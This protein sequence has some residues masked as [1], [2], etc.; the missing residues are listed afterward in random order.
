MSYDDLCGRTMC[1]IQVT[2]LQSLCILYFSY[3]TPLFG[4]RAASKASVKGDAIGKKTKTVDDAKLAEAPQPASQRY[5]LALRSLRRFAAQRK[6]GE[7][8]GDDFCDEFPFIPETFLGYLLSVY[9]IEVLRGASQRE[10]VRSSEIW[11]EFVQDY[12]VI[13]TAEAEQEL[14]DVYGRRFSRLLLSLE[15]CQLHSDQERLAALRREKKTF[16]FKRSLLRLRL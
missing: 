13:L 6:E 10:H 1:S 7:T 4:K 15:E 14:L 5:R 11:A 2:F 9:S 8:A 16:G 12:G 3:A